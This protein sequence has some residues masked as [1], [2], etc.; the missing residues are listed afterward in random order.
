MTI[1]YSETYY[2]GDNSRTMMGIKSEE[3]I[4]LISQVK[5]KFPW[6]NLD[7]CF[8]ISTASMHEVLNEPVIST[9]LGMPVTKALVGENYVLSNRKYCMES[10]TSFLRIYPAWRD[11]MPEFIPSGCRALF[12]G[13][14]HIELNRPAPANVESFYEIYFHGDPATV[15]AA[16][17]L[18]ERRGTYDTFY[19]I[20]IVN[21][22]PARVKQYVYDEQS[23]FS[24]WD[25]VWFAHNKFVQPR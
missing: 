11:A 7:D 10:G 20:T 2:S 17:D 16:F 18:P 3:A 5:E 8:S 23:K 21:N 12:K 22:Q 9:C 24:D 15:E 1:A 19:G 6:S 4:P 14:N 25:V 13:E